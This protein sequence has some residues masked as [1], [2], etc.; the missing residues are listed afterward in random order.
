MI[1]HFAW[2]LPWIDWIFTNKFTA[3]GWTIALVAFVLVPFRRPPA[4]ARGW[5]LIFFALPWLALLTYAVVGRPTPPAKRR[6]RMQ[7]LPHL[8]ARMAARSGVD[9][10]RFCPSLSSD[11]LAVARLAQGLGHFPPFTGNSIEPLADYKRTYDRVIEDIASAREHVHLEF[12]IFANDAIGKLIMTA[13]EEAHSRGV[14]C[15]VLIDALGSFASVPAIRRR[16]R[17]SGIEV[18]EI[19]PLRRRWGSSRVD[20]RNHRKIIVIDGL[21]A[22]T[23]SQ[24]I[25]DPSIR[26]SR[27]NRD[28]LVRLSGPVVGQAQAV[29]ATDWFLETLEE[30]VDD[31]LFPRPLEGGDMTAQIVATGPDYPVGGVDLIF[32]QAIYN[33][34]DEIV[35]TSPYFIPNQALISAI[36]AA[37]LG[38]V[39]VSLITPRRSDHLIAGLAQRSYYEELL[40]VGMDIHL[41]GPEFLHAK[42]FRVDT[43][44]CVLGSSN[45][46]VRSF[47]LNAEVDLICYEA[48]FAETVRALEADYLNQSQA[49][50]PEQWRKRPL[51]AKVLENS[52]R[53]MSELI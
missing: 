31:A 38:G 5:L 35:I 8:F 2:T 48:R 46:D 28:L 25:W 43:E 17:A 12:Y 34:A 37:I 7:K 20:L 6:E 22:Y 30:L 45:M 49:L 23:G 21:I 29:F 24:N 9:E 52:A 13:L 53:L 19:L 27:G 26:A 1:E 47:E 18:H 40:A 51:L 3:L 33:A 36:K 14:R 39:R 11:N 41:Y 4:E 10:E 50:S 32:A 42:H 16:L 44:V 15:R